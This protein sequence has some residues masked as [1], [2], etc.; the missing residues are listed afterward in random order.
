MTFCNG[1]QNL[2][3]PANSNRPRQG[4]PDPETMTRPPEP[5]SSSHGEEKANA[6]FGDLVQLALA[7]GEAPPTPPGLTVTPARCAEN[8][9]TEPVTSLPPAPP[10]PN[11]PPPPDEGLVGLVLG[12]LEIEREHSTP[13]ESLRAIAPPA[14][15]SAS[16]SEP[17]VF[18]KKAVV[19]TE[20]RGLFELETLG[21][22][23]YSVRKKK[24]SRAR[25]VILALII[26]AVLLLKNEVITPSEE[27]PVA[28][29]TP[30]S[31]PEAKASETTTTPVVEPIPAPESEGPVLTEL[32]AATLKTNAYPTVPSENGV[33]E[34]HELFMIQ[35]LLTASNQPPLPE[36]ATVPDIQTVMVVQPGQSLNSIAARYLSPE[37]SSRRGAA[38]IAIFNERTM[39]SYNRRSLREG[40]TLKIPSIE[41]ARKIAKYRS[42]VNAK[43]REY[44][45]SER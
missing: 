4:R 28:A 35:E 22:D 36:E 21:I 34:A 33:G 14:P 6:A 39:P 20:R 30:T 2:K 29:P 24:R 44:N 13:R 3:S 40:M 32:E 37:F 11:A 8:E 19:K 43:L 10:L 45:K 17:R 16:P 12:T 7:K 31:D 41:K 5:D 38:I 9:N 1:A 18:V 23:L 27:P 42:R 25:Y 26:G 15:P